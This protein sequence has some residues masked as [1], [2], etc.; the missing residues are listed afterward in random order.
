MLTRAFVEFKNFIARG[1]LI[2]L[3]VAVVIGTAFTALVQSFVEDLVTPVIAAIFGKSDFSDLALTINGSDF[4]YGN[5]INAVIIFVTVALSVF[6]LIIRPVKAIQDRVGRGED[7]D[8]R[9]CPE[10]LSDIPV[11]ARRC[12]HCTVQLTPQRES[13]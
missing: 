3:A 1:N 12:A 8:V 2:D 13:G 4:R 5:F 11:E 9:E 7:P 10:C 6:F